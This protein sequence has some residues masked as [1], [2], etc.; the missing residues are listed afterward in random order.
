MQIQKTMFIATCLRKLRKELLVREAS[1]DLCY[2][3]HVP[4]ITLTLHFHHTVLDNAIDEAADLVMQHYGLDDI[5]NPEHPSQDDIYC[6]GRI[7]PEGDTVRLTDT[8][9]Q[10]E[11]SRRYGGGMRVPLRFDSDV[12]V[13]SS[14]DPSLS[15]GEGGTGLFPG[16][17]VG[18]KGRNP[19]GGFFTASE[20]L[21]VGFHILLVFQ[22]S[23]HPAELQ[24]CSTVTSSRPTSNFS[25]GNGR[26]P[27]WSRKARWPAYECCDGVRSFHSR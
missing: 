10:L 9:M 22:F 24:A 1:C 7:C 19:G 17:I 16:M 15:T 8:S 20:I 14:D 18:L 27:A 4:Q 21:L 3:L 13:R 26:L 5:G 11:S 23:G 12:S 2:A 25:G 6:V